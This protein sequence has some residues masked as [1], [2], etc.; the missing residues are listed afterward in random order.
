[1]EEKEFREKMENLLGDNCTE[2]L[3]KIASQLS[4]IDVLEKE[5]EELKSKINK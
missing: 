4:K 2:L 5:I 1:M 3:I